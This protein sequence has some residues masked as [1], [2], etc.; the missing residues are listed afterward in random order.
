MTIIQ[1]LK[2]N[3]LSLVAFP[4]LILATVV[5][6]LAKA[7]EKTLVIMGTIVALLGI[8]V[9]CEAMKDPAGSFQLI[10]IFILWSIVFGLVIGIGVLISN[11]ILL[12]VVAIINLLNGLYELLNAGY[13]SIYQICYREYCTLEMNKIAKIVSC[14]I[15]SLIRGINFIITS[16]TK[17]A[18]KLMIGSCVILIGYVVFSADSY[19]NSMFGIHLFE[20]LKLFTIFEAIYGVVL[21]VATLVGVCVLLISLGI[22]WNEWGEEIAMSTIEYEKEVDKVIAEYVEML[23]QNTKLLEHKDD[24]WVKKYD[25]FVALMDKHMNAYENFCEQMD[26][27]IKSGDCPELVASRRSYITELKAINETLMRYD[28][29]LPLDEFK[30]LVLRLEKLET[31]K[32]RIEEQ[33]QKKA[34]DTHSGFFEGCNT[35]E[36]LE[37]R[38]KALCKTYHPDLEMGDEETFKKMSKEYERKKKEMAR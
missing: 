23:P 8:I 5:K 35:S 24:K 1:V 26:V 13:V 15:Y 18:L 4:L 3:F 30:N 17:H 33:I 28:G 11:I 16:F 14:F 38:Y 32:K 31:E 29:Q 7:M 12:L 37:K 2:I 20:Y 9:L 10:V 19:I 6:L 21:C 34:T 27:L 36:K 22:E 25:E